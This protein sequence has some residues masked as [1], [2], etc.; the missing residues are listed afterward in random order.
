FNV[1]AASITF[2]TA[3]AGAVPTAT[4]TGLSLD[5]TYY[6][7]VAALNHAGVGTAF[8][9]L[10]STTTLFSSL[11]AP[12]PSGFVD[13]S[14]SSIAATWGLTAGATGYT[15]VA[16]LQPGNPPA[17]VFASSTTM[18][19]NATTAAVFAPA[20]SANTTYYL[21]VR[22][23]GNLTSS[24]F[25]AYPATSTLANAPA[26]AASTFS[27]VTSASAELSWSAN[28]NPLSVTTYTIHASTAAD[29]NAFASSVTFSTA[30][31]G[32]PSA[33]ISGL[34]GVTTY[35]F[36][37]RAVNHNGVPTEFVD[38]GSTR[39]LVGFLPAPAIAG[40]VE[41]GASSVTATWELVP[42]ATGYTLVA[43]LLPANPP[44]SVFASSTPAGVAATTATVFA[45]ALNANTTYYFFVR[46]NGLQTA[47]LYSAYPAT[48]TLA[49]VPS[50]AQST[51]AAVSVTSFSV[52]WSANG[53]PVS[54]T[55][56]TVQLSTASDFNAFASSVA[57]STAP[58]GAAPSATFT[59]LAGNTS[60]YFRVRAVNHNG[61]PTDFVNLGS[62]L[63]AP[64]P[65]FPTITDAQAG[66]A[67]W[68]RG[69]SGLYSVFFGDTSGSHLDKFQVKASTTAGGLGNDLVGFVDVLTNLGPADAFNTP[70]A[71]PAGFFNSLM[72]GVT[73]YISVRVFNGPPLNNSTF[74]QD[75]FHILKDTTAPNLVDAQAGDAVVRTAAG[76][77]YTVQAFDA[78]GGLAAFQYSASLA[79]GTGN[80]A[81]IAWTNIASVANTTSYIA[82]WPVD[83]NA[84]ASGVTN[85]ISVRAWDAAGSTTT[86]LDAF[87]VLKD[88]AGPG[89]SITSPPDASFASSLSQISGAATSIFG[90]QGAEVFIQENPPA[91]PYWNPAPVSQFNSG[92]PV[93]MPASG[94]TAWTLAPGA[95]PL[96]GGATYR[97][98][99]R[100]ST[101][102]NLYSTTYAT[103]TFVMDLATPTVAVAAPAPDSTVSALASI[104]GTANDPGANPSGLSAIEV[105]LR[106]NSDEKWWNWF[107]QAWGPT[108]VS[109][110]A[111]GTAAWSLSPTPELQASL[112]SGTSY[113]IAARASDNALP[114]NAGD[115]FVSGATFT[116]QDITPPAAVANL[117]AASGSSPGRINLT[118]TA[119]GD[120]AG[121]GR[122]ET[123]EYRL[124]YST[125]AA[126]AASTST[127]QI[128]ISTAGINPGDAQSYIVTGLLPGVTYYLRLALADSDENWSAFSNQASTSAAASPL[129][130]ISGR[131]LDVST[132]GITAV[133]VDCWNS[134]DALVATTFTLA[135]GSGTYVVNGLSA[136][137]YKLR[138]TWTV[139]GFSSSLWQDG[140]A[141]GSSNV[142]F[143]LEI[144]YA[145]ATLTGTL[146][147][148]TSS[149][150][151]GGGGLGA[152]SVDSFVELYQ[153]G[154]QVAKV[155]VQPSGRWTI[156]GLLP[157]SYSV[158][159]Y[160]GLG[161]TPFQDVMLLEG[162]FRVLGFVFDPLPEAA[163]FAFPNPARSATTIRFESALAPLEADILIFDIAGNLVREISDSQISRAA[164]PVYRAEWDLNNS[165]G[166]A[167]ASGVYS[168]MVKIKGGSD[169]QTAKVIKKVAVVR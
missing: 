103:S 63:T 160:T 146:S 140:I 145:L 57:F 88:T 90:V 37:V 70:W 169:N 31:A 129:N 23:N 75:A 20:L 66:D 135:D 30:P 58:A 3:P 32:A 138:V 101:T 96:T 28:G 109:S 55:T 34:S 86:A 83:F 95:L 10:G 112:E 105:R 67:A 36:R 73:N 65:L 25:A 92:T 142:D 163:V 110:V 121:A 141:M 35:Y 49:N 123:G 84:L 15:M 155:K 166:R 139:N 153:Q 104:N 154:R 21:F 71:L 97:A 108:A 68:R 136:G 128:L 98:V 102:S 78:G 111:A 16:S 14:L 107:T 48:S 82:A 150:F 131:V 80:A 22:A 7:R 156:G 1:Y 151:G 130:E 119:P 168:V 59:G 137:S 42:G 162:E 144:N 12:A 62:T 115:F 117:A 114:A 164:A 51:F 132:Q 161:Y 89:V 152:A 127:A 46:A 148:L 60:Y 94:T 8:V 72:D 64:S 147:T 158:R 39:T 27:V 17:S 43:S 2:S 134:A 106:R 61:L 69:D 91:G 13:V 56:Y 47:S 41:V 118:W 18:D 29:F 19:V 38:L 93:W 113:F 74:L 149:S 45:P 4:F 52:S 40:F 100:S 85:Y 157:G 24:L 133:Q 87:Y 165:A 125:D 77:T 143:F 79:P 26:T 122:L 120:D 53:N 6:F 167:V 116:W 124:F 9:H 11:A 5:T 159:A 99:A 81:V 126:A 44:A 54:V 50:T 76:T 33:T